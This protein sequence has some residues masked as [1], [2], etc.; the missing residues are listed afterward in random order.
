MGFWCFLGEKV[1]FLLI[2]SCLQI[3]RKNIFD[4]FSFLFQKVKLKFAKKGG[5]QLMNIN[6]TTIGK[7]CQMTR[8]R[9]PLYQ[10]LLS[11]NYLRDDI[12]TKVKA[13]IMIRQAEIMIRL[14]IR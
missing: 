6:G 11:K 13:E 1:V 4:Q 7:E 9:Q 5:L 2:F 14:P 3:C 12:N 10:V 8:M